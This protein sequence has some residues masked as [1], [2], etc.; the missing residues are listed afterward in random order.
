M[1]GVFTRGPLDLGMN[2]GSVLRIGA[3]LGCLRRIVRGLCLCATPGKQRYYPASSKLDERIT[4][5]VHVLLSD[6]QPR[7]LSVDP[8]TCGPAPDTV[9]LVRED[10]TW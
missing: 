7:E 4:C 2:P 5:P 1:S 6:L 3:C 9:R 8:R 10:R